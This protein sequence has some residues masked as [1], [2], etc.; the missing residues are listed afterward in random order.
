MLSVLGV[1]NLFAFIL[2]PSPGVWTCEL[3][4]QSISC[5]PSIE[6]HLLMFIV[7]AMY[8]L[9]SEFE[10]RI[11]KIKRPCATNIL[12]ALVAHVKYA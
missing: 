11:I 6:P 3:S 10:V 4:G 5:I 12:K 1:A 2:E 9:P 8:R 7:N